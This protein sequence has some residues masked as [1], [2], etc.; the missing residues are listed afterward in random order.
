MEE[1]AQVQNNAV[2]LRGTL[3]GAPRFSHENRGE[4]FYTFPLEVCRLSGATD[5]LNIIVRQSLA[6][7][8]ETEDREK[9][10]VRG[11][12]RS[13]NN[14]S[15]SG[16]KLVIAAFARELGF[17]NGD[18]TNTVE[19]TGTLC[20]TPTLRFTPMGRE[21]CDMMLAVNRRYGRSDYLPCIAWGLRAR[22]ASAW[23]VGQSIRLKGR[24]QSR[25]YTK[26]LDGER[27]E[28]T[29]YEISVIELAPRCTFS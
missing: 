15:G 8:L 19:L 4:R 29:A 14:K 13:F 2:F 17:D 22:L 11:E 27:L 28:K 25:Q 18:D 20:K 6:E 3:A 26:I 23:N 21:I 5:V 24:F 1:L 9:C 10:F 16:P 7:T 12:I